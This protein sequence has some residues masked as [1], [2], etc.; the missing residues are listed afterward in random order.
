MPRSRGRTGRPWRRA[1]ERVRRNQNV[2]HL[3]GQV[4]DKTLPYTH[5]KS[6]TV[7]HVDPLSLNPGG[8]L[9]YSN[10]KAAHRSCNSSKGNGD[11]AH[12]ANRRAS[13]DW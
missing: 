8:A 4:I 11:G 7:D 13:R 5:P 9:D 3:C 1:A 6:F 2:C 12:L 10:L